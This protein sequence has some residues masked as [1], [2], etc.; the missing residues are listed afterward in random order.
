LVEYVICRRGQLQD[1]G[2]VDII[3]FLHGIV[4]LVD[5][6]MQVIDREG[7]WAAFNSS[8]S[9]RKVRNR[10]LTGLGVRQRRRGQEALWDWLI[11]FESFKISVS[12]LMKSRI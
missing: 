1:F 4:W 3:G 12:C 2:F 7:V 11:V 5:I 6:N 9:L 10:W 8:L